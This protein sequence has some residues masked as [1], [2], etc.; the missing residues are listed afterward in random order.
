M[1]PSVPLEV[2]L[3]AIELH[4]QENSWEK[5]SALVNVPILLLFSA[6]LQEGYTFRRNWTKEEEILLITLSNENVPLAEI[7]ARLGRTEKAVGDRRNK[8]ASLAKGGEEKETFSS[9]VPGWG[10]FLKWPRQIPS[11]LEESK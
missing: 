3:H 11:F 7:A 4:K 8:I 6:F 1:T 2:V 9:G 10:P 5:V